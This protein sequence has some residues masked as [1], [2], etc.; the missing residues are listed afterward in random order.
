MP[1][2]KSAFFQLY[3]RAVLALL[4]TV[5]MVRF[6]EYY[7]I[8]FKSFVNH[9]FYF[10]LAG[11]VYDVWACLLY[12]IFFFIPFLLISLLSKKAAIALFHGINVLFIIIYLSLIVVFSERN[13]P[14]DHEIFNYQ[15]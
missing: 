4:L 5:C 11:W 12:G 6:Y 13:T 2:R 10:E 9:A 8:A 15:C 14:F 1:I 3:F 7:F